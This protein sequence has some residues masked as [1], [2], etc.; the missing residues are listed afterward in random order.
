MTTP[1]SH[2]RVSGQAKFMSRL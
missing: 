1:N 2:S